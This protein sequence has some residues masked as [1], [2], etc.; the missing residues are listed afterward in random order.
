[1]LPVKRVMASAIRASAE[2]LEASRLRR[3]SSAWMFRRSALFRLSGPGGGT[4]GAVFSMED[5]PRLWEACVIPDPAD[6]FGETARPP[7]NTTTADA[8]INRISYQ[9]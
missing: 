6:R 9:C 2:A 1:M 3:S 8:L 7:L 5:D 4:V